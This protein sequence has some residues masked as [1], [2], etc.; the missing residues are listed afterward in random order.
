MCVCVI[1][2]YS[3]GLGYETCGSKDVISN[4][5]KNKSDKVRQTQPNNSQ[6]VLA[7]KDCK[8]CKDSMQQHG[9]ET[10]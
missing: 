9:L 4:P 8:D 7:C 2:V 1:Y 6:Q 5:S 10:S 3:I